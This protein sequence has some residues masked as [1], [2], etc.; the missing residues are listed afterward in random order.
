MSVLDLLFLNMWMTGFSL[1]VLPTVLWVLI[2]SSTLRVKKG[3]LGGGFFDMGVAG[4]FWSCLLL[5]IVAF[6]AYL[7]KRG[8]YKRLK[9]AGDAPTTTALGDLQTLGDLKDRGVLSAAEF[10]AKKAKIL[11]RI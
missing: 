4:W 1:V 3:K 10:E 6:P 2:D 5:W 8:E 7:A 11:K 9:E